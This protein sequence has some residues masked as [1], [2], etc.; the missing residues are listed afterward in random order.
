MSN[1]DFKKK[2]FEHI[3][4]QENILPSLKYI[5]N[6]ILNLFRKKYFFSKNYYEK[7]IINSIIYNQKVHIVSKFKEYLVIDDLSDFLK[8]FYTKNESTIRLPLYFGYYQAYS[9]IFPNYTAIKESKYIYKNIHRKQK[10]IDMQQE[11]ELELLKKE[12]VKHQRKKNKQEINTIFN[13]DIYNSIIKQSQDLYM[14]LFGIDKNKN[15]KEV[16][17][18]F[19]SFDIKDIV[20]EIDKYD[21]E[22]KIRFNY[23][24]NLIIPMYKNINSKKYILKDNNSS[25]LTKQSTFNSSNLYQKIK[26]FKNNDDVIVGLKKIKNDKKYINSNSLLISQKI[27]KNVKGH[28]KSLTFGKFF[29]NLKE[30][31]KSK[32]K[33]KDNKKQNLIRVNQKLLIDDNNNNLTDRSLMNKKCNNLKKIFLY[34]CNTANNSKIKSKIINKKLN[35]FN[36]KRINSIKINNSNIYRHI[37]INTNDNINNITELSNKNRSYKA[38]VINKTNRTSGKNSFEKNNKLK[39]NLTKIREL[40][41]NKKLIDKFCY[42][43]RSSITPKQRYKNEQ[44]TEKNQNLEKIFRK[45]NNHKKSVPSIDIKTK[46]NQKIILSHKIITFKKINK[47]NYKTNFLPLPFKESFK[48]NKNQIKQIWDKKTN[49]NNDKTE[50]RKYYTER[51]SIQCE[52]NKYS[53]EKKKPN[54]SNDIPFIK[55]IEFKYYNTATNSKKKDKIKK[56]IENTNNNKN[57]YLLLKIN[58]IYKQKKRQISPINYYNNLNNTERNKKYFNIKKLLN[59]IKK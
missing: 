40:I 54:I 2:Y 6:H 19:S 33:K 44:K 38:K 21:Y 14:I 26:N 8:R 53:Q 41:K 47:C 28:L 30:K 10:M 18:S 17:N 34:N 24:N 9:K 15:K 59:R 32:S 42:T 52:S 23:K 20:N 16:G 12:E 11:E 43:E 36:Y 25:L 51:G 56:N 22:S 45:V 49:S 3:L 46:I 48:L 7:I 57:S 1:I 50:D 58:K 29:I 4:S 13:N 39:I 31:S 55:K 5:E 37:R 35:K 27:K